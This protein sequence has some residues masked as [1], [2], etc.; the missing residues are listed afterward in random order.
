[1][2]EMLSND[3]C[4]YAEYFWCKNHHEIVSRFRVSC[5]VNVLAKIAAIIDLP[6]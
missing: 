6:Q 4:R 5:I 2:L 1:M 3:R